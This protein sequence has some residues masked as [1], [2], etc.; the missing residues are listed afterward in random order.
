MEVFPVV[1]GEYLF[2]TN[3]PVQV[4]LTEESLTSV[5][6]QHDFM[7][8]AYVLE[9]EGIQLIDGDKIQVAKGDLFV[10]PL[11]YPMCSSPGI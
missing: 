11:R 3:S 4:L 9:G 5:L 7:E 1:A 8:I 10:I 6:H 2:D